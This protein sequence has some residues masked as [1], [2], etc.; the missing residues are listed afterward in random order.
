MCLSFP[1]GEGFSY[2]KSGTAHTWTSRHMLAM[3]A[4]SEKSVKTCNPICIPLSFSQQ[5]L[6]I[7]E[8][9][10]QTRAD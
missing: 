3:T 8:L 4:N 6:T 10:D 5:N 9:N 1:F 7:K 2:I